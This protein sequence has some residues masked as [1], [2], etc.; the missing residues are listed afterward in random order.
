[1]GSFDQLDYK[2]LCVVACGTHHIYRSRDLVSTVEHAD[3][4]EYKSVCK[5]YSRN[6]T[7]FPV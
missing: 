4:S 5:V 2:I 1:M 7:G 6:L 3:L